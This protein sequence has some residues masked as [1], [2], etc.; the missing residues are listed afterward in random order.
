ML[1]IAVIADDLTGA[2]DTGARL[3]EAGL[4]TLLSLGSESLPPSDVLVVS[5]E[6]RHLPRD[7]AASRAMQAVK[8]VRVISPE[9]SPWVYKKID[10]TLRGHPGV[11]LAAIMDA[12]EIGKALVAPAFPAQGRTTVDGTQLVDRVPVAETAFG[13]EVPT[14]D[15]RALFSCDPGKGAGIQRPVQYVTLATVRRGHDAV[16]EILRRPGEAVVV[17]DAATDS[18]LATLAQAAVGCG[19]RLLCGSAGLAGALADVLQLSST[20]DTHQSVLSPIGPVL[21]VAG[22]PHPRTAEQV[23]VARQHGTIVV[24]PDEGFVRDAS[25]GIQATAER[26]TA[27]LADKHDAILTTVGLRMVDT[28]GQEIADRLARTVWNVLDSVH[29]GGLVLTGGDVAMAVCTALDASA[30]WIRGEVLPGIPWG[31]LEGGPF[32]GVPLVT[33]AG[34]FGDADSLVAAIDHC[35]SLGEPTTHD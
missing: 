12:L 24:K 31:I 14:S 1:Q 6:S 10:S 32:A 7:Q 20:V 2:M 35:H 4:T 28:S 13:D 27:L 33:K 8:R 29:A 16:S 11:E 5:T 17:A 9:H 15:V 21:A 22:S 30:I 34:G 19:V 3:A 18:D 23:D 25:G 26:I